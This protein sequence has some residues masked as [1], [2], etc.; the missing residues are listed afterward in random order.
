[1]IY[2]RLVPRA[3]RTRRGGKTDLLFSILEDLALF[4]W[5][6]AVHRSCYCSHHTVSTW[7]FIWLTTFK[8]LCRFRDRESSVYCPTFL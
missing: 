7:R 1:M 3:S 5:F 8:G 2:T 4:T 6:G